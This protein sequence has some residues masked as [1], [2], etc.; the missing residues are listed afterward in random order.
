MLV[1]LKSQARHTKNPPRV[2]YFPGIE[3]QSY[4]F[5]PIAEQL[6]ADV[7]SL[8]Y[9]METPAKTLHEM[10]EIILPVRHSF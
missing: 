2:I 8:Q 7:I 10:K 4:V 9:S 6:E 5:E 1:N 3:G